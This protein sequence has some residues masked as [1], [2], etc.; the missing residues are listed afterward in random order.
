MSTSANIAVP[1]LTYSECKQHDVESSHFIATT[2]TGE[3]VGTVR[4]HNTTGQVS[5]PRPR[6]Q[7]LTSA[8]S[9]R[10]PSSI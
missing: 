8:R 2:S 7:S 3:A 1:I 5:C 4:I 10:C 9:T 6:N